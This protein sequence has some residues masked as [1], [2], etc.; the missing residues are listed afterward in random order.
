[1]LFCCPTQAGKKLCVVSC[2]SSCPT[3]EAYTQLGFPPIFSSAGLTAR[4]RSTKW[5]PHTAWAT[6]WWL[7]CS[8]SWL[9]GESSPGAS[10]AE[11]GLLLS[12]R[13]PDELLL[14]HS[15]IVQWQ[16][17][18][19]IEFFTQTWSGHSKVRFWL[20]H[21]IRGW[22]GSWLN[23]CF[24]LVFPT[25]GM[26]SPLKQCCSFW[27]TKKSVS[28]AVPKHLSVWFGKFSLSQDRESNK[29]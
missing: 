22:T 9:P 6:N 7:D 13:F 12:T 23:C 10:W 18:I 15:H 28:I 19:W 3:M 16:I 2:C 5:R 8:I 21:W 25:Q 1:M 14:L 24:I 11:W 4:V 27:P 26:C 20:V 29:T 17:S